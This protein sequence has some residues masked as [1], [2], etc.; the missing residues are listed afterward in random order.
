MDYASY[1]LAVSEDVVRL[2]RCIE[3]AGVPPKTT[4]RN[5]L[6]ATWNLRHFGGLF[7]SFD[8]NPDSPKRNLR[9]LACIAEVVRCFDVAA[10]QEVK[11]DLTALRRLLAWLGPTWG[12]LLS[13]VT[14]GAGG[15]KE[16]LAFVYDRRR[17][18]ASGLAGEIVLPPL[19]GGDPSRQFARTPYAVSFRA[20]G[21]EFILLTCHVLYGDAPADRVEELQ[22]IARWMADWAQDESRF[23]RDLIVL[24]DFNIDREGDPLFEAFTSTGLNVPQAIRAVRTN[25]LGTEAKHYDQ[26][27]WFMGAL[28]MRTTGAAGSVDFGD[29][30][31][32]ELTRQEMSWR[33]SDHFPLWV[34]FVVDRSRDQLAATLGIDP[35]EPG[36]FDAVPD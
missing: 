5:L 14:R 32:Q 22:E 28:T 7:D 1:P 13:D 36:A 35:D 11:D 6:V 17:V 15:N 4:D 12:A 3:R 18:E 27:A 31:F 23:H 25:A 26:I 16:R 21:E 8:E 24:G 30:V 33:V 34:E 10:I 19:P 29:A 20:L 2:R 9:G